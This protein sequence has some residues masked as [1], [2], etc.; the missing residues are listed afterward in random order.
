[1]SQLERPAARLLRLLQRIVRR[2]R[3]Y[4][5]GIVRGAMDRVSGVHLTLATVSSSFTWAYL[6]WIAD[7]ACLVLAIKAIGVAVPWH[8]VLPVW[9][10]GIGAGSFSRT[11]GGIGVIDAAMIAASIVAGLRSAE[12]VAVV[13]IWSTPSS[14]SRW[15]ISCSVPSADATNARRRE[16]RLRA[17]A[18][19]RAWLVGLVGCGGLPQLLDGYLQGCGQ[20]DRDE[21]GHERTERA[22]RS[23]R[24]PTSQPGW[25]PGQAAGSASSSGS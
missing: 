23:S 11:P 15:C 10:A 13:L 6:N 24:R 9:S 16:M 14:S 2:P 4:P 17:D 1:M 12:A 8:R 7:A 5:G 18:A 21:R 25:P 3:G 20:R 22:R 19:A